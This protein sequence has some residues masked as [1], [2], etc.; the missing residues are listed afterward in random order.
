MHV[1]LEAQLGRGDHSITYR[2]HFVAITSFPSHSAT[3]FLLPNLAQTGGVG[4]RPPE[5]ACLNGQL[6][7]R[8]F[9]IWDFHP[10]WQR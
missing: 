9:V 7:E 2:R 4:K 5:K 6:E 3:P 1:S 8:G 10:P